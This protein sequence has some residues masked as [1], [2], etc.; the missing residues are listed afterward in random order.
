MQS[1]RSRPLRQRYRSVPSIFRTKGSGHARLSVGGW[2][3]RHRRENLARR[4]I[5]QRVAGPRLARRPPSDLDGLLPLTADLLDPAS[6]RGALQGLRPTASSSA[7]GCGKRPRPKNPDQPRDGAQR[8]DALS[9]SGTVK[10]VALV[11]GLKHYLGPFESYG[12]G[13]RPRRRSAKDQPR[14]DIDN[15][16]YAQEDEA[17]AA[18]RRD[19]FGWSVHRAHTIIGYALGNAM[20]MGVTLAVYA[21]ICREPV[22]RFCFPAPRSLE[23]AH[24]HDGCEA[25]GAPS[26]MR[27]RRPRPRAIRL[28]MSSMATCSAVSWM[29]ARLADWFGLTTRIRIRS[30]R[31]PLERQ[32]ADA[33]P[34]WDEHRA[35]PGWR[36]AALPR[37]PRPGTRMPIWA[38][39]SRSSPI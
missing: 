4:L 10:H 26:G 7:R 27:P 14:L 32:L 23:R 29:W 25:A 21:T 18:A 30:R 22:G 1:M 9:P 38:V 31:I 15:F 35:E 8:L 17:F 11:T 5:D 13:Y 33:D 34:I 3:E 16:Y 36:I 6:L 28:S 2:G 24:R 39:R 37:S 12:K 20:N 19:G